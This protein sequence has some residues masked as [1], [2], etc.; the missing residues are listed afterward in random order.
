MTA[1]RSRG[2]IRCSRQTVARRLGPWLLSLWRREHARL[3][4]H[5]GSMTALTSA[6]RTRGASRIPETPRAWPLLLL[7]RS[8]WRQYPSVQKFRFSAQSPYLSAY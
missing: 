2:A 6:P 7:Q 1:R 5:C 8:W 3:R 4:R